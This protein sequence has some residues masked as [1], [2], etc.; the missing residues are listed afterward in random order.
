ME[1]T[2]HF[3]LWFSFILALQSLSHPKSRY[4]ISGATSLFAPATI[5]PTL[6]VF[7]GRSSAVGTIVPYNSSI[8]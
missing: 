5:R 4:S 3:V 6:I 8:F 1:T 7:F 2:G